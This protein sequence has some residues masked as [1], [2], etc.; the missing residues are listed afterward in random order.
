MPWSQRDAYRHTKKASS[1]H[2]QR[3]WAS[4]AN[5]VLEKGGDEARAIREA[6]SVVARDD[7]KPRRKPKPKD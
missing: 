4:V 6:N 2:L 5:S 1:P 7:S 3:Q